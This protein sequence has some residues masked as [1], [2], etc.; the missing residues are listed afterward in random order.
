MRTCEC[1]IREEMSEENMI[2][3]RKR[4][5]FYLFKE[6]LSCFLFVEVYYILYELQKPFLFPTVCTVLRMKHL[7]KTEADFQRSS[8]R[9]GS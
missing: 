6:D 5:S 9:I 4:Y 7:V 1:G 8:M 2:L 3:G